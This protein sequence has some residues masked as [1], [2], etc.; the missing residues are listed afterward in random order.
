MSMNHGSGR[1]SRRL[2][3][4]LAATALLM[5]ACSNSDDD[6]SSDDTE[7]AR[8]TDAAPETTASDTTTSESA[9]SET[10]PDDTAVETTEEPAGDEVDLGEFQ[11][12]EGV[13]GVTDETISF[14]MLGTGPSNPLGYCLMECFQNGAQAYFDYRNSLGGVHGRQLAFS[15]VLDDEVSNNQVKALELTEA[16]DVFGVFAAPLLFNGFADLGNA[17]IPTYTTPPGAGD[18]N[19]FESIYVPGGSFCTNCPRKLTVQGA[20]LAG[21]TK[22]AS[23]G[24][25]ASQASKDCAN[26]NVATFEK[27]GPAVGIEPVYLNDDLPFGFPNGV[28]PEVTA[29]NEAGVDYIVTCIDISS[30]LLLDQELER[31]GMTDVAIAMPQGYGDTEFIAQ[32]A[33]LLEGNILSP[34]FRPF[35]ADIEGTT[36]ATFLEWME[37]GGY[38]VTDN[39]MYAWFGADLA[40]QGLLAAGPQFDR[41]SVVAATNQFTEFTAGGIMPPHDWTRQHVA[42]TV[43]DPVTNGPAQECSAFVIVRS[44]AVELAGDAAK[45]F[46]CFDPAVDEWHEPTQMG[47]E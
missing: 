12:I 39:A 46:F 11:P 18:S 33:A 22:V 13:P 30:V 44:G 28:A 43:D 45:P 8:P 15:R 21:A 38:D 37:K 27:W 40:V 29:M 3:A 41:A 2:V 1:W 7:A 20:V 17:G 24:L 36:T 26:N 6:D 31:Q 23:L 16:D 32:N 42:P 14:G 10:E 25:G 5:S 19:G 47:F 34:S 35:E 4:A 9:T